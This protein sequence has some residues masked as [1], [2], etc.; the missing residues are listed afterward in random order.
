MNLTSLY[1]FI[2]QNE[3]SMVALETLLTSIPALA[4]EAGGQGEFKKCAA[5]TEWLL[6]NGLTDIERFEAPDSRVE[7]GVRPSIVVTV[8]GANDDFSVWIMAHTDVV[9]AGE[10]SLWEANP[11]TVIEKD[12]KLIGR[13]VED[14]QQGL[15]SAAFAALAFVKNGVTPPHTVKLLFMA[16]EEVGST[17]G[18][19]WLLKNTKLFRKDDLILIP[20]GGDSKGETIEIAEKNIMWLKVRVDGK[21]IHASRPD[22]GINACLAADDLALRL[23]AMEK[24]F[25]AVDSLFEPDHSTIEPTMRQANVMSVNIIPGTD[26]FYMDCRILPCYALDE[27]LA[28]SRRIADEVQNEY[29]VKISF[30]TPNKSESP[31]TPVDAKIV[32]RL[33]KALK[34]VHGI[35]ART[36]GIGGGT[37]AAELRNAGYHAAV[38]STLDEQAHM[39]NEYCRIKNIIADAKTMINLMAQ[40]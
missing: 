7:S 3:R 6:S 36:I 35:N 33:K 22:Q 2:E 40:D 26:V 21:Q 8:P 11:W 28:E 15:V 12:G 5:L 10:E 16:D 17:Y 34:E 23:H 18:I 37:V 31:A 27:V 32:T 13:G 39:P 25:N 38:W 14:N 29:G 30:E 20:D 4:P 19:S 24:K 9:A 1:D